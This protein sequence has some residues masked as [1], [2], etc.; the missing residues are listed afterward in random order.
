MRGKSYLQ[1]GSV[2]M[3]IGGS[4]IDPDFIE[5]YLGM[6]VESVDEVEL[7]RRMTEGIYDEEE[8]KKALSWTKEHCI[9]GFDKNP[10]AVQKTREQK[11]ADWEF[12]VKMMCII[13]DLMNGNA[14]LP[15]GCEE[16]KSGT[17]CPG[18][19]FPGTETVDR[20]LS[21]CRLCRSHV[22]YIL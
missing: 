3:G 8:F 2:T 5:S 9:E 20:L 11:D 7:I 13:K 18:S 1:I 16:E 15:E 17:Q 19:R 6:R 21:Q 12:V 14:N 10:E 4:I 22:K